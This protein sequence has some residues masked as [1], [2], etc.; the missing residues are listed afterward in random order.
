MAM[1]KDSPILASDFVNLKAR[2]KAEM[3]R[4]NGYNS[5]ATYAGTTYDYTV[6]PVAQGPIK[7]EHYDKIRDLMVNIN[8]TTVTLPQLGVDSPIIAMNS[9]EANM[10][11]FESKA[12]SEQSVSDCSVACTG[13]CVTA[14]TT[15]C[16]GCTGCS[17][18]DG[19]CSGGCDGTC[20][21][22]CDGCSGCSGS[23]TDAC[24]GQ[25]ETNC[26]TSCEAL[27]WNGGDACSTCTGSCG[28]GCCGVC[29]GPY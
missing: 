23:C 10:T 3:A 24:T 8:S 4:R 29:D 21:G 26:T 27:C 11:L 25:C 22:S 14:C 12:R 9:L 28:S 13:M 1:T 6:A 15:S 5:L 18:C 7:E 16:S 17:G 20:S 2:V 19:T